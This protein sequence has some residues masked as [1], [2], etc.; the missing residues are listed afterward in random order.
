MGRA[1]HRHGLILQGSEVDGLAVCIDEPFRETRLPIKVGGGGEGDAEHQADRS[2][3]RFHGVIVAG[4][5]AD[6]ASI[7][8]IMP[9]FFTSGEAG[10][11]L[12]AEALVIV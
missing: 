9:I 11:D 12:T 5:S 3:E 4:L 2:E 10:L 8:I 1:V 6:R 7:I